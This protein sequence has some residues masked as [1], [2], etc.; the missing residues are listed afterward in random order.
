MT[1]TSMR[2]ARGGKCGCINCAPTNQPPPEK[3]AK[4]KAKKKGK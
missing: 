3:K 4:K 2:R 1:V